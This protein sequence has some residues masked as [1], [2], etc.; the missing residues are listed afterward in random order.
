VLWTWD[1]RHPFAARPSYRA[2]AHLPLPERLEQLR[3]PDVKA[4]IRPGLPRAH[5][6]RPRGDGRAGGSGRIAP[7]HIRSG[8]FRAGQHAVGSVQPGECRLARVPFA[9]IEAVVIIQGKIRELVAAI[10]ILVA[11]R[12]RSVRKPSPLR[13]TR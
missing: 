3:R 13:S 11:D 8:D 9:P 5:H 7:H 1:V 2:I 4:A 6:H 12:I 10:V